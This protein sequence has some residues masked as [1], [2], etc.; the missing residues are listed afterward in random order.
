MQRLYVDGNGAAVPE[1][2]SRLSAVI[3]SSLDREQSY[4][5]LTRS[6]SS[7]VGERFNKRVHDRCRQLEVQ[8]GGKERTD[9]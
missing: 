6:V 2:L 3:E 7:E 1:C 9:G 8:K 5:L 4:S